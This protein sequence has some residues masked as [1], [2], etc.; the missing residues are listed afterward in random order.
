MLRSHD[1]DELVP[2]GRI[3]L[4]P[5]RFSDHA[6]A[7]GVRPLA[8]LSTAVQDRLF[9]GAD[10]CGATWVDLETRAQAALADEGDGTWTVVQP[11]ASRSWTRSGVVD[12]FIAAA[13]SGG[14]LPTASRAG[15]AGLSVST[16]K[17]FHLESLGETSYGSYRQIARD[18]QNL[19]CTVVWHPGRM[20]L[21]V[22]DL[23]PGDEGGIPVGETAVREGVRSSGALAN[24]TLFLQALVDEGI[25]LQLIITWL[26]LGGG[27]ASRSSQVDPNGVR[28]QG[29]TAAWADA[30]GDD[31]TVVADD[32]GSY[33]FAT[34]ADGRT[35]GWDRQTMDPASRYKLQHYRWMAHELGR[36]FAA[37]RGDFSKQGVD[38]ARYI[39]GIELGNELADR[40]VLLPTGHDSEYYGDAVSWAEFVYWCGSAIWE[41]AD[42]V[43][44][45]L[46]AV[47]S[48]TLGDPPRRTL[49]WAGRFEFIEAVLDRLGVLV[50]E[51]PLGYASPL[52]LQDLV[53]GLD[54][55]YYHHKSDYQ[56]LTWIQADL[57]SLRQLLDV[58]GLVQVPL[59][60]QEAGVNVACDDPGG[61]R[62]PSG[63]SY[64]WGCEASGARTDGIPSYPEYAS[65]L[66]GSSAGLAATPRPDRASCVRL[67]DG[68]RVSTGRTG[69]NDY[70][71]L[72]LWCRLAAARSA[73]AQIVGWHTPMSAPTGSFAAMGLRRDQHDSSTDPSVAY[74]R[75]AY[76]A[77]RRFGQLLGSYQGCRRLAVPGAE[78]PEPDEDDIDIHGLWDDRDFKPGALHDIWVVEF[79]APIDS[80]PAWA[81]L[82]FM[83]PDGTAEGSCALV[84]LRGSAL[85]F[86]DVAVTRHPLQPID[87]RTGTTAG[88]YPETLWTYET[89]TMLPRSPYG[90]VRRW[91]IALGQS[92]YPVLLTS[93][94]QLAVLAAEVA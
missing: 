15:T 59:T 1:L 58:H 78:Y 24:L 47:G 90:R 89:P 91:N 46:P 74:Q 11:V 51:N 82:L 83:D 87:M 30:H 60:V 79:S 71:A 14:P 12:G 75:P 19:G 53:K 6:A 94:R 69:A 26:T 86:G 8:E 44:L 81:Y 93:T 43:P 17:L 57:A 34:A 80:V 20:Q 27:D 56:P 42:W 64:D 31:S 36:W 9:A 25:E 61:D 70:Q 48:Y 13:P 39:A 88:H 4:T 76:D 3:R 7:R 22:N 62:T 73:G 28:G 41:V 32:G 65:A 50:D 67:P 5:R 72:A 40:H 84:T 37:L 66:G 77:Y 16:P 68:L 54:Y 52:G 45:W 92:Q 35:T 29:L 2:A 21:F 23:F 55:H 38:I 63:A 49:T 18:L 85:P 10:Q 33:R